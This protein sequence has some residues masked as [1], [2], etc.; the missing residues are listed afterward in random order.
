[1]FTL[2]VSLSLCL[3]VSLSLCLSVSLSL[4]LSVSLSLC[5]SV[6][7]SLC[8][9]VSLSLCLSLCLSVSLSLCLSV[10]LSLCLSVSLSLSL[11]LCL[12]VSLSLCLSVSLSLC[13]YVCLSLSL[14]LSHT[15]SPLSHSLFIWLYFHSPLSF[16]LPPLFRC[17][18]SHL[19]LAE[20]F[21]SASWW[22]GF[23]PQTPLF[24]YYRATV[25]HLPRLTALTEPVARQTYW[26]SRT[27]HLTALGCGH[28]GVTCH[29]RRFVPSN[30][31]Q[32][33]VQLHVSRQL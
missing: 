9:S 19:C 18:F 31:W 27:Q 15:L 6:S 4:C 33:Y 7:L 20:T 8:L 1:M 12:S 22:F 10:S 14:S 5:L 3:S 2:S 17:F 25:V 26:L 28:I 21:S 13:M 32:R 11:S 29:T 30:V 16:P 24:R 23:I